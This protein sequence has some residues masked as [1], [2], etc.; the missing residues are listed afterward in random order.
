MMDSISF[1][2]K[3]DLPST[4]GCE[5]CARKHIPRRMLKQPWDWELI[6]AF[7]PRD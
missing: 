2:T 5:F 7:V 1:A 6:M 3:T 4:A